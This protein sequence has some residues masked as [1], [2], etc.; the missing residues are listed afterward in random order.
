MAKQQPEPTREVEAVAHIYTAPGLHPWKPGARLPLPESHATD[1][2]AAGH[3]RDPNAARVAAVPGRP[4][5]LGGRD[6][7]ARD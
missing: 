1:L 5:Q 2:L 3:V 4:D 6:P 7:G